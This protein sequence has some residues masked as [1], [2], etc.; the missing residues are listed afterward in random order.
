MLTYFR[1]I[2]SSK[3]YT[4]HD[5]KSLIRNKDI[6]ILQGDIDS[7]III[8]NSKKYHKTFETKVSIKTDRQYF[9]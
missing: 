4:N 3:D 6:K 2:Y 9:T 5:Q 1:G 8:M 7:S